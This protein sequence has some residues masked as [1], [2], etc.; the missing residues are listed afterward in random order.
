MTLLARFATIQSKKG[1]IS[2]LTY[3]LSGFENTKSS[4]PLA[5]VA[6]KFFLPW[7]SLS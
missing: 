2:S 5:Q 3:R 6:V 7:A 4:L 1:S